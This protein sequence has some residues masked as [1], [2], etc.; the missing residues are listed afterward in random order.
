[1]HKKFKLLF[2][3]FLI[4]FGAYSQHDSQAQ[5]ILFTAYKKYKTYQNIK[6]NFVSITENKSTGLNQNLEGI[7][8]VKGLH[9]VIELPDREIISDGHTIWTYMKASQQLFISNYDPSD[10]K[11][12]P[13]EIF[14][15]DFLS[16]GLRYTYID[17]DSE[18]SQGGLMP[19][20]RAED[21]IEFSP[22]QP[23]RNYLNFRLFI[24]RETHLINHWKVFMK[25][26]STI[27]YQLNITPDVEISHNFFKYTPHRFSG[28]KEVIDLR[29]PGTVSQ[30]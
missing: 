22:T 9:H 7:A 8:Y 13:D 29:K 21:V 20:V 23:N 24:D 26:G 30:N 11:I 25:N 19:A 3:G 1:M 16:K 18:E 28:V 14:R 12:T 4:S 15:E 10:G 2:I 6:I 27:D 5:T 17:Q